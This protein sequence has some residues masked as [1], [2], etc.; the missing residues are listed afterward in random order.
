MV[1]K[2]AIMRYKILDTLLSNQYGFYTITDLLDKVNRQLVRTGVEPVSRRCIEK[3][4]KTLECVPYDAEIIREWKGR[5]KRIRYEEG[6]SIFTKKLTPDEENLLS[7]VLSTLGQFEGLENFEWLEGLK[8][9]LGVTERKKIIQFDTNPYLK[10]RNLLGSLFTAI[11]NKQ[12]LQLE[13]KSYTYNSPW[14]MIVHPYLLKEYNKRWYLLVR[15]DNGEMRT[16]AIDRIEGFEPIPDKEYVETDIDLE[17]A[18]ENVV[19]VSYYYDTEQIEDILLWA[20]DKVFPYITTKPLH[21]SQKHIKGE[22][23]NALREKYPMFQGGHFIQLECILN[24][25]LKQLIMYYMDQIVVLTPPALVNEL[26][27]IIK[28]MNSFYRPPKKC[29]PNKRTKIKE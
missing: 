17:S 27:G 20:T 28:R 12:V 22:E 21:G 7:E 8:N 6:F 18:F 25:E 29:I 10:N 4:L 23:E 3:D 14:G 1:K 19:G 9:R 24:H 5:K 13:Y 2:N 15:K 11:S 16:L 26:T